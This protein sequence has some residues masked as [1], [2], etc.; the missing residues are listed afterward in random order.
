M[1]PAIIHI[2]TIPKMIEDAPF[3]KGD[4][5]GYVHTIKSTD[6]IIAIIPYM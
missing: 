6:R 2:E 3:L 4:G 1:I 5:D